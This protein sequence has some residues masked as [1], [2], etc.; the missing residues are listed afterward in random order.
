MLRRLLALGLLVCA[1]AVAIAQ[2]RNPG[3]GSAAV[4]V[5]RDLAAGDRLSAADVRPLRLQ[6]LPDGALALPGQAGGRI[7]AGPVRR[8]EILTDARLVPS[9]GP[10]PGPGRSA[11]PITL[12]DAST[13][14][15]LSPGMHLAVIAVDDAGTAR[16]VTADAVVLSVIA[17]ADKAGGSRLIL[18]AVAQRDADSV[19]A[20][21]LTG[22]I[23]VRFV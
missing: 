7:L 17:A 6:T 21:T 1:G 9:S 12:A 23:A 22:K 13:A 15:L 2:E 11:V 8:G 3:P 20:D 16:T 10:S 14:G 5:V 18:L 19:A 4:Q